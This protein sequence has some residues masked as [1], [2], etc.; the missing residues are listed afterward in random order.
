MPRQTAVK[1][2]SSAHS[3]NLAVQPSPETDAAWAE[4]ADG[5]WYACTE[6]QRVCPFDSKASAERAASNLR[7]KEL[8][9]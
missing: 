3:D 7:E 8:A 2:H 5:T 4:Q 9:R 1:P 6:R